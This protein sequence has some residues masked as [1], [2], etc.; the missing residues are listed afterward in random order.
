MV[1]LASRYS[2]VSVSPLCTDFFFPRSL[3]I[4]TAR[5]GHSPVYPLWQRL[6]FL[7]TERFTPCCS[8]TDSPWTAFL[9]TPEGSVGLFIFISFS[10]LLRGGWRGHVAGRLARTRRGEAVEDTSRGGWR[11]H[12]AGRLVRTRRGEAGEDTSWGGWRGHIA[13]RL[14]RT[15]RGEAGARHF[16]LSLFYDLCV[17]KEIRVVLL[18][19]FFI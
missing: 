2:F 4:N 6:G 16:L 12:V 11:G 7:L 9:P 8:A 1:V 15:R 14:V 19:P 10:F 17:L 3:R 18:A 13:G 5:G